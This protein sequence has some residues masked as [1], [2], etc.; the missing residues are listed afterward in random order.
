MCSPSS[1]HSSLATSPYP[2]PASA[3][4]I[5]TAPVFT[6]A[7]STTTVFT[8]A[9]PAS[10]TSATASTTRSTAN[11][12]S[13]SELNIPLVINLIDFDI[14]ELESASISKGKSKSKKSAAS[15]NSFAIIAI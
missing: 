3:A 15:K 12:F 7:I 6:S 1:S 13:F 14:K 4:F 8:S 2:S 10:A 11:S 5:P 9:T